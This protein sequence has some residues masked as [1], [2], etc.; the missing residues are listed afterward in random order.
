MEYKTK[1][2]FT[3]DSWLVTKSVDNGCSERKF[4]PY[5]LSFIDFIIS[6]FDFFGVLSYPWC[7]TRRYRLTKNSVNLEFGAWNSTFLSSFWIPL[8]IKKILI[9]HFYTTKV[10]NFIFCQINFYAFSF[11]W[12][13]AKKEGEHQSC[14]KWVLLRLGVIR[15]VSTVTRVVQWFQ[16]ELIHD[17]NPYDNA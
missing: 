14:I 9:K 6:A 8:W 2:G 11:K 17:F 3:R 4:R 16:I 10:Y 15:I 5:F 13:K 12:H 1:K 7:N